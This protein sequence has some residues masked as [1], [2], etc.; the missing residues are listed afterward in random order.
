MD[1]HALKNIFKFVSV[2]GMAL[3]LFLFTAII[4]GWIYHEDMSRFLYF[5]LT[6]FSIN[7]IIVL[8]L[9]EHRMKLSIKGGI[10][11]VNLIWVLLGVAGAVP[12]LLYT[13]ITPADAFFEAVSGFTTTGATVFSDIESLPKSILCLRSLMHWLGGMGI[14]V[15]GVGLFSLINPSGSMTLFK[16]ESTG[17]KME[18][19][20]PKVKDTAIRLWGIYVLFTV[21]DAIALKLAGMNIFDAVNHAFSTI[22]TGGFSTK[23]ASLGYY[24]SNV[25]IWITTFFMIISGI[26]FLAHLKL[27]ST[28]KADGYKREEVLWYLAIFIA[29]SLLLSSVDIFVDY[30]S[31]FHALTHASFTVASV[32]TTTGFATLDYEQWGHMAISV[33]F[34]AMLIGGNA[35]STAG[36]VK[37][38]RYIVLFKNISVQFKRT[39]H[40]NAVLGVFID[41]QKVSS[42]IISSTTGFIFLFVMTNMFLTLY[43]FARGFDAMT[44]VSTALACVGNI[45]P[46]FALTGPAH[47][48]GFFSDIDK[49]VLSMG[50]IIGRL[51]FYTVFLLFSRSFWKK[52]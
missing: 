34:V 41:H 15:L 35:G 1:I 42:Q 50:M 37:V 44:S 12:F 36:G 17:I 7:A 19:I 26:N 11:S 46:G 10:L 47:N 40:P 25:I 45:G 39:L 6:L 52:F 9:R 49:I 38:I 43:L 32:L 31:Y 22:S 21:A 18:K 24:D 2:I 20:T 23:N 27:F 30:D 4:V 51:E 3:S 16:A 13:G 8:L 29:L 28:G 33:I 5:D 14:I 48:Y